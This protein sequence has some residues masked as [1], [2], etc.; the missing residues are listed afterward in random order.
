VGCYAPHPEISSLCFEIS[1]L[2]SFAAPQ[3]RRTMS[4]TRRSLGEGG[5]QGRV[6]LP[7]LGIQFGKGVGTGAEVPFAEQVQATSTVSRLA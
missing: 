7:I 1:T 4:K 6:R 5:P 2:S 3:L